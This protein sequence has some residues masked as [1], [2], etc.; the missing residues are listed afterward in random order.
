MERKIEIDALDIAIQKP[1]PIKKNN[2]K[3]IEIFKTTSTDTVSLKSRRTKKNQTY[4][5]SRPI[6]TNI[7]NMNNMQRLIS[8]KDNP[9]TNI[10]LISKLKNKEDWEYPLIDVYP[11][12]GKGKRIYFSE[13]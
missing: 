1:S 4:R 12:P 8:C 7:Y 10:E 11:R 2:K 6:K 9:M 13:L 5:R 3:I